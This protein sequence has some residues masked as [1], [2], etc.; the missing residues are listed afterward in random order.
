[1]NNDAAASRAGGSRRL[2]R[3]SQLAGML[4]AAALTFEAGIG[5]FAGL[6]SGPIV[7]SAVVDTVLVL[8]PAGLAVSIGRAAG[9][10]RRPAVELAAFA[11]ALV[12]IKAYYLFVSVPGIR[13]TSMVGFTPL[14]ERGHVTAVGWAVEL[15]RLILFFAGFATGR[16]FG[17]VKDHNF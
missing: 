11:T 10:A 1:M 8:L 17:R 3:L 13:L 16:Y 7:L 2:R 12:A 4:F 14:F 15:T 9:P 5:A 6:R